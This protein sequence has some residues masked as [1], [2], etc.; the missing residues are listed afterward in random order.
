MK[1]VDLHSDYAMTIH[2]KHLELEKNI[3]VNHHLPK[4]KKGKINIV[5]T[6][7]GGDFGLHGIDYHDCMNV[8]GA[9]DSITK[10]I[11]AIP[12]EESIKPTCSLLLTF[13]K[14][15]EFLIM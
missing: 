11:E 8:I 7:V 2:Q 10:E 5:I 3:L 9:I 15:L 6:Q 13:C 1:S 14:S 4:L 12:S